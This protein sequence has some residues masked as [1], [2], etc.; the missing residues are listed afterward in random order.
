MFYD[1]DDGMT[2]TREEGRDDGLGEYYGKQETAN[3]INGL[4][5]GESDSVSF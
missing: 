1:F 2:G 4:I 3:K 5:P